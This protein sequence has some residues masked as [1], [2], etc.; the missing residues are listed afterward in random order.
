MHNESIKT[1]LEELQ[2]K[3]FTVLNNVIQSDH[4]NA[5]QH[6]F[7]QLSHAFEAN[8]DEAR[9]NQNELGTLRCL[10]SLAPAFYPLF[11]VED[12]VKLAQAYMGKFIY[13]SFNGFYTSEKF[14]HPTTMFHRD[15]KVFS[16]NAPLSLNLLYTL[17]DTT[18]QNGATWMV[19]GSH[20]FEH[21][22]SESFIENNKVQVCVPAGSVLLFNSLTFHASGINHSGEKR[23]C[24]ANVLRLPFMKSQFEWDSVFDDTT[25]VNMSQ[26]VKTLFGFDSKPAQSLAAYYAEGVRRREERKR[27]NIKTRLGIEVTS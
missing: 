26:E 16:A 13:Y 11:H 24:I 3:G 12:V 27:K 9:I 20:K 14:V 21:K 2:L 7:D 17:D 23:R 5:M 22:P 19:P 6:S 8:F 1:K 25:K 15:I 18:P 4:L 10:I